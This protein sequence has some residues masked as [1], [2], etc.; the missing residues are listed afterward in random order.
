M[1][2]M[3]ILS[4]EDRVVL[5]RSTVDA[6]GSQREALLH[7][8]AKEVVESLGAL[9]L[10]ADSYAK[11]TLDS[12]QILDDTGLFARDSVRRC[13]EALHEPEGGVDLL[14]GEFAGLLREAAGV[15]H[16]GADRRVC[17]VEM[18]SEWREHVLGRQRPEPQYVSV[19]DVAARFGVTTQA[20]YKWLK[21]DRIEATRGPGGSW[22]IPAA[23]FDRDTRPATSRRSLDEL[24]QHLVR[25]HDGQ[26][27]PT[28]EELAARMRDED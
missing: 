15:E 16:L 27:L 25:V 26:E 11:L 20:V 10:Y 7:V 12:L 23:Q 22:R 9:E 1:G 19:G 6:E 14:A 24:K 13:L 5:W 18:A 17:A 8:I 2:A 28:E 4:P 21:D 3:E